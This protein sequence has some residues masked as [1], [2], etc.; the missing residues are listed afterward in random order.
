[1]N[2]QSPVVKFTLCLFVIFFG[3]WCLRST[4]PATPPSPPALVIHGT[5]MGTTYRVVLA[6]LGDDL[7][8][9]SVQQQVEQRLQAINQTMSTYIDDSDLSQFNQSRSTDWQQVSEELFQLIQRAHTISEATGGAFDIT[10]GPA[11]NLW[12]FGPRDSSQERTLP[13]DSAIATV[14]EKIGYQHLHLDS[15]N[16][17]LKKDFAE[18]YVD[19]SAIAKGYAVDEIISLLQQHPIGDGCLV[20]IGG[21]IG[22]IGLRADGTPWRIGIQQPDAAPGT[23]S[24]QIKL[25]DQAMATSGDYFN[26]FE[27]D[28]VRYSHT[29]DPV[30]ARPVTHNLTS[31]VVITKNCA[32]ADAWATALLVLGPIQAYDIAKQHGLAVMLLERTES[33]IISKQTPAFETLVEKD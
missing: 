7:T 21:E 14:K 15:E 31:T 27:V 17:S 18:L 28:G 30:T 29:I 10:V 19:L 9:E 26:F 11:V 12:Q 32:E 23:L 3:L 16:H 33:G 6:D 24:T 4:E 1:M 20:E 25:V 5:T 8:L 22:T 13:S 2:L